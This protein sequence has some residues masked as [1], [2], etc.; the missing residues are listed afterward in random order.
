MYKFMHQRIT[1][2]SSHSVITNKIAKNFGGAK[3]NLRQKFYMLCMHFYVYCRK[4][5]SYG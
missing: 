1:K 4:D 2:M 3:I 5:K